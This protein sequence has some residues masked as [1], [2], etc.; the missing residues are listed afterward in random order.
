MVIQLKKIQHVLVRKRLRIALL[1]VMA[2]VIY[3]MFDLYD[4][5]YSFDNHLIGLIGFG[6]V[7][8]GLLLRSWAAGVII[9]NKQ[10]TTIG[11]YSLW[12]HPLYIGSLLLTIGF[13][14]I[15][16][17]WF[18][19][20]VASFLIIIIYIPKIKEEE[21]KLKR[22]F[23]DQWDLYCEKTGIFLLYNIKPQILLS[24]WSLK[25]WFHNKEY[26]AWIAVAIVI[27]IIE[28]WHLY[29]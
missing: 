11:P 3:K 14:I 23:S 8:T 13:C 16:R 19:W 28:I 29:Y 12:R 21:A 15:L 17:D 10:L 18:L 22:I 4:K 20:V 27:G 1:I 9:K 25:Q 7:I 6:V 2:Y 24:G 26:N 5:P